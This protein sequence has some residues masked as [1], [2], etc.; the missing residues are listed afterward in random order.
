MVPVVSA[1]LSS[2]SVERS[3]PPLRGRSAVWG[4]GL[5]GSYANRRGTMRHRA[6]CTTAPRRSKDDL[7]PGRAAQATLP[8]RGSEVA[9]TAGTWVL[10]FSCR[11]FANIVPPAG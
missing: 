7:L 4:S 9:G 10:S 3:R 8:V 1:G 2:F 6:G 5:G 11:D